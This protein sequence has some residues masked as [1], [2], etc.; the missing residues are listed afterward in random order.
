MYHV[1]AQ[2]QQQQ[3]LKNIKFVMDIRT[4]M[5]DGYRQIIPCDDANGSLFA[6]VAAPM[7]FN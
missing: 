3:H 5:T 2:Q 6:I 4:L 7:N 1:G